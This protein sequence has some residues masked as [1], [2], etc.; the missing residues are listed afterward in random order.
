MTR[1]QRRLSDVDD[2]VSDDDGTRLSVLPGP[3]R[4]WWYCLPATDSSSTSPLPVTVLCPVVGPGRREWGVLVRGD[5]GRD[6]VGSM[7]L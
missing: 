3:R 7:D 6:R 2:D 1:R 4:L 5:R